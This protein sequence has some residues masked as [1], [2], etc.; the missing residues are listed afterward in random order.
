MQSARIVAAI[1]LR[2]ER[3]PSGCRRHLW[4]VKWVP[5]AGRDLFPA[6]SFLPLTINGLAKREC[7]VPDFFTPS[8]GLLS[9]LTFN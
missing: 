1:Q 7:I 5:A 2:S 6:A 9:V 8:E 4:D 3:A